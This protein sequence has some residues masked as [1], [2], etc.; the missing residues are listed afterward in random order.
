LA[1]VTSVAIGEERASVLS[2]LQVV[3]DHE[4][5]ELIRIALANLPESKKVA[6]FYYR[7]KKEKEKYDQLREQEEVAKH[8]TVRSVTEAYAQIK[9]LDVQI[10]QVE[11]KISLS[12][13]TEAIQTEL[14]LARAEVDAKRTMKLA[15]LREVMNI[16]P[17]HAFGRQPE[18][19][20]KNWAVLDVMGEFV[21]V[22]K[23]SRPYRER[24]R[25]PNNAYAVKMMSGETA[26][27]YIKDM[28]KNR[29]ELPLRVT[30]FRT[31]S[32]IKVS[33]KLYEQ[34]IETVKKA[35]AELETDVYLAE[36][37]Q[38]IDTSDYFLRA[39]KIYDSERYMR[40]QDN[41]K[42][43]QHFFENI[44][45]YLTRPRNLPRRF[46]IKYDTES[47]DLASRIADAIK[48]KAK[49]LGVERFVEIE[50][51]ETGFEIPEEER[52]P[53]RRGRAGRR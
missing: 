47:K 14:I 9:L 18:A 19:S 5:G 27:K 26:V 15:E 22:L 41:P 46:H 29:E 13:R 44:E 20:L 52:K 16:V 39:G 33:E 49:E 24:G 38:D 50:Q 31:E 3:D 17:K 30:I 1:G 25:Y 11:K 36:V 34:V 35:K 43:E 48:A 28:V 21:Y 2:R 23:F 6:A 10:E 40:R 42:D 32:G 37:R 8:G 4:L 51:E 12:S 7:S 53:E 45:W